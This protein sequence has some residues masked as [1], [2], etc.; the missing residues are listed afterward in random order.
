[1][2][3]ST[4]GLVPSARS[5]AFENLTVQR[6]SRSFWRSFAGL[7]FHSSGIR[8]SLIAFFSSSLLRCF[9]AAIRFVRKIIGGLDHKDFE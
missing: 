6:A 3:M 8:P 5:F 1:M 4:G 7:S 9:G 2:A